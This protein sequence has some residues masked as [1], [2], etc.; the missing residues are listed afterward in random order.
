MVVL[1]SQ[2]GFYSNDSIVQWHVR[3]VIIKATSS[4][5]IVVPWYELYFQ[6][7]WVRPVGGAL[8]PDPLLLLLLHV[9]PEEESPADAG[10]ED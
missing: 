6:P 7:G 8:P 2:I 1:V 5:L 9:L 4:S 3:H 10:P